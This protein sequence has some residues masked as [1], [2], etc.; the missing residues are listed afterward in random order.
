LRTASHDFNLTLLVA[1]Q[2]TATLTFP[3]LFF[4]AQALTADL[5]FAVVE[6]LIHSLTLGSDS[7]VLQLKQNKKKETFNF[8]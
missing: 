2:L 6:V 5:L 3:E 8:N 7:A 1:R 4:P